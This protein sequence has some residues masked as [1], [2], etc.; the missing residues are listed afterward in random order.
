MDLYAI[1][2][3]YQTAGQD[4]NG[5]GSSSTS[6]KSLWDSHYQDREEFARFLNMML[7]KSE[8]AIRFYKTKTKAK[9]ND[10]WI[11]AK[12]DRSVLASFLSPLHHCSGPSGLLK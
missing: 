5:Y 9:Q 2:K 8:W 1:H 6:E 3:L 12:R 10:V 7:A 11:W 4:N